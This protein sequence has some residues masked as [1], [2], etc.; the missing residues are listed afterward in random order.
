MQERKKNK[1]Y[2]LDQTGV[3]KK[4]RKRNV[5]THVIGHA[6]LLTKCIYVGQL[7]KQAA[8]NGMG[9][10]TGTGTEAGLDNTK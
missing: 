1:N 8:G 10:G 5:L 4:Y 2:W 9:T 7:E 6:P 3:V